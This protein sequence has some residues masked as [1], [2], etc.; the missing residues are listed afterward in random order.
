M[1]ILLPKLEVFVIA[2][3]FSRAFKY[4]KHPTLPAFLRIFFIA[5]T[6]LLDVNF[7]K[8]DD[9]FQLIR[10]G[11]DDEVNMVAHNDPAMKAQS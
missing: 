3:L 2:I 4:P 8:S 1:V 7:F 5:S 10:F 9:V 11:T 6:I